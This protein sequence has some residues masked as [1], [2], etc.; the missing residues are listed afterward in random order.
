MRYDKTRKENKRIERSKNRDMTDN[1]N[2]AKSSI[3]N[4]DTQ[5]VCRKSKKSETAPLKLTQNSTQTTI[6]I[7]QNSHNIK[8]GPTLHAG[9]K[10]E[11]YKLFIQNCR[12]LTTNHSDKMDNFF[13]HGK[14]QELYI[15]RHGNRY[16]S[17]VKMGQ[18]TVPT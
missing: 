5:L 18:S 13:V 8:Y 2:R 6:V 1:G 16:R 14:T 3:N 7:D 15:D 11:E 10:T 9:N 17:P 4:V 12:V